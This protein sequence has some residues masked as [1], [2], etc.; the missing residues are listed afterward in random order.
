MKKLLA[1]GLS[2]VTFSTFSMGSVTAQES[3][4]I[5]RG[6][7]PQAPSYSNPDD[8]PAPAPNFRDSSNGSSSLVGPGNVIQGG[9]QRN[10]M[11]GFADDNGLNQQAS[12]G[13]AP[14]AGGVQRND[15]QAFADQ[16]SSNLRPLNGGSQDYMMRGQAE[17][18]PLAG[19]ITQLE[20]KK[21]AQHDVVLVIDKSGSMNTPDCPGVGSGSGLASL[22]LG[23]NS[24]SL[25]HILAAFGG[26]SLG[27]GGGF[28]GMTRW[29]WCGAQIAALTQQYQSAAPA[30]LSV[31][32]FSTGTRIFP[33]VKVQD[34]PKIFTEFRPGGLTNEATA[35]RQTLGDY[36]SRKDLTNGNVKPLI[37]AIITDG[38]PTDKG[39]VVQV[40]GQTMS[41]MRR[42]D[43]IRITFLQV[44]NTFDGAGFVQ[45]LQR[46]FPIVSSKTFGELQRSGLTRALVDSISDRPSS[47]F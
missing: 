11:Q 20:L 43:E 28:G 15:M 6:A 17:Q 18:R 27:G 40:I 35:L 24:S 36:F 21:L 10:D 26:I 16:A 37:V 9:V 2:L 38:E 42:P 7:A 47:P 25:M 5:Q 46:T 33:N 31:V 22:G 29:D 12:M 8:G 34:I 13:R 4:R 39:S 44:G 23:N 14:L 3:F 30:G 32:L 41:Q 45:N 1:I 19:G